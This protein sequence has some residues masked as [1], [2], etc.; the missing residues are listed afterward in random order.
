MSVCMWPLL[1]WMAPTMRG[2]GCC[3]GGLWCLTYLPWCP[4]LAT[5]PCGATQCSR[6]N[7]LLPEVLLEGEGGKFPELH[8]TSSNLSRSKKHYVGREK[9]A[10]DHS[11]P[12]TTVPKCTATLFF[13][14]ICEVHSW[15]PLHRLF[16]FISN[17]AMQ[18]TG[19]LGKERHSYMYPRIGYLVLDQLF[20][21]YKSRESVG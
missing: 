1:P 8:I 6:G 18:G 12:F 10:G 3:H 15:L 5:L 4:T 20:G 14:L 21:W 19:S 11:F 7:P 2:R 13:R 16:L 9:W 17:E